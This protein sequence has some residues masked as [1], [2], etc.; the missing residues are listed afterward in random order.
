VKGFVKVKK[1][2]LVLLILKSIVSGQV[3]FAIIKSGS[4]FD[5]IQSTLDSACDAGKAVHFEPGVYLINQTLYLRYDC[6]IY[7]S[8]NWEHNGAWNPTVIENTANDNWLFR[9]TNGSARI[10]MHN[11]KLYGTNGMKLSCN[12]C[13]SQT[14]VIKE[15]TFLN[16]RFGTSGVGVYLGR[17]DFS[18]IEHCNF[19]CTRDDGNYN[20]AIRIKGGTDINGSLINSTQIKISECAFLRDAISISAE[21]VDNVKI[22]GNDFGSAVKMAIDVG[23]LEYRKIFPDEGDLAGIGRFSNISIRDNHFE[24]C[25]PAVYANGTG[26]VSYG[27]KNGLKI[28]SNGIF[29]I[30]N[31]NPDSPVFDFVSCLSPTSSSNSF[32]LETDKFDISKFIAIRI[33]NCK[34]SQFLDDNYDM[35]PSYIRLPQNRILA[36][37]GGNAGTTFFGNSFF[38]PTQATSF[39]SGSV[40]FSATGTLNQWNTLDLNFPL[41]SSSA[42]IITIISK[43]FGAGT[44]YSVWSVGSAGGTVKISRISTEQYTSSVYDLLIV[45]NKLI[46]RSLYSG[47]NTNTEVSGN[48]IGIR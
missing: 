48:F 18:I 29:I 40:P 25:R 8:S 44:Y 16:P 4:S 21:L 35:S 9:D 28:E 27:N 39:I 12:Q 13:Y 19:K 42:G 32:W 45:D 38:G 47:S 7:G 14:A 34:N 46:Y 36:D 3:D 15:C 43:P 10:E 11:L 20:T 17:H 6:K 41:S 31:S 26:T 23:G 1:S 33:K 37:S 22:T 30:G 24:N 5:S 2:I